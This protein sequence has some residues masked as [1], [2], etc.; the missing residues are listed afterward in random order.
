M[1]PVHDIFISHSHRDEQPVR[2]LARRLREW[3]FDVCIDFDDPAL[4]RPGNRELAGRL[5]E[6]MGSC[7]VLLFAL[8]S[9]AANSKWLPWQLG[10][11]HGTA[12]KVALWPLDDGAKRTPRT[13]EYLGLYDTVDPENAKEL[14]ERLVADAR[15]AAPAPA[16]APVGAVEEPAG[17]AAG[18]VAPSSQPDAFTEL[19][20]R[21]PAQ[22][23]AAW[24]NALV[25]K[26]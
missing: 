14:L 9:V 2:G 22:F 25:G 21:G 11:A 1:D 3:G 26:R 18:S 17:T 20:L 23:Y 16:P 24:L 4:K 10:L 5:K 6:R 8:S 19:V 13:Q 15:T 12:G 7:R